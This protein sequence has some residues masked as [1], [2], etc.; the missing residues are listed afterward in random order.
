[1]ASSPLDAA[2]ETLAT[3]ALGSLGHA[4]APDHTY[5]PVATR[6]A[7][8]SL[9]TVPGAHFI[10][11]D[12]VA[13]SSNAT[14]NFNPLS[15]RLRAEH[16]SSA[17]SPLAPAPSPLDITS[18]PV[19]PVSVF[20]T[21]P[22]SWSSDDPITSP[23]LVSLAHQA[24][25]VASPTWHVDNPLALVVEGS[26]ARMV[27]GPGTPS[28]HP[29]LAGEAVI[30]TSLPKL[31]I[32]ATGGTVT[33][34]TTAG[35][36]FSIGDGVGDYELEATGKPASINAALNNFYYNPTRPAWI[37]QTAGAVA[38]GAPQVVF[39][40]T[41]PFYS[42]W[43]DGIFR[44]TLR[45]NAT[46]GDAGSLD[47]PLYAAPHH[48]L[49]LAL[50][51]ATP[52]AAGPHTT[53]T[54]VIIARGPLPA[55]VSAPAFA[56]TLDTVA[57]TA[58][59]TVSD[60]AS[61]SP[62]S[63]SVLVDVS[64]QLASGTWFHLVAM[65]DAS[66]SELVLYLDGVRAPT[67]LG[68][69]TLPATF[70]AN[71]VAAG[72]FGPGPTTLGGS[73]SGWLGDV[74]AYSVPLTPQ[75]VSLLVAFE[76]GFVRSGCT[77]LVVAPAPPP[78]PPPSPPPPFAPPS[79]PAFAGHSPAGRLIL[80]PPA[81]A[82]DVV[83][84]I[85]TASLR[86]STETTLTVDPDA[87]AA[88]RFAVPIPHGARIAA[89]HLILRPNTV[90]PQTSIT[91]ITISAES[92][93][94]APQLTSASM[95]FTRTFSP[96]SVLWDVGHFLPQHRHFA[97]PS[98]GRSPDLAAILQERVDDPLWTK[99]SHV[100]FRLVAGGAVGA[101]RT[102]Y[103]TTTST[104]NRHIYAPR[105]EIEFHCHV[106]GC[107]PTLVPPPSSA[108]APIG[109]TLT[110][111]AFLISDP[112]VLSAFIA[113]PAKSA[114]DAY[115]ETTGG[116]YPGDVV[117]TGTTL[118]FGYK[119]GLIFSRLVF[120]A[121]GL[122]HGAPVHSAAI[123]VAAATSRYGTTT[124]LVYGDAS[125]PGPAAI[126]ADFDISSR[127]RTAASV[128]FGPASMP[129]TQVMYPLTSNIGPILS[130]YTAKPTWDE[131]ADV[132]V[133]VEGTGGTDYRVTYAMDH[134]YGEPMYMLEGAFEVTGPWS[135]TVSV[136]HGN[137]GL[138]PLPA[139]L[140]VTSGSAAGDVHIEGSAPFHV[141]ESL[142]E[143]GGI[144]YT[145]PAYTVV[146]VVCINVTEP[147]LD[148]VFYLDARFTFD[149]AGPGAGLDS[150]RTQP[151]T[152]SLAGSSALATS[153][154]ALPDA[155]HYTAALGA[156]GSVLLPASTAPWLAPN[157][158]D[159][160]LAFWALLPAGAPPLPSALVSFGLG[161][162]E[163]GMELVSVAPDWLTWVV[164]D[165]QTVDPAPPLVNVT[166]A[167]PPSPS[168]TWHHFG[169]SLSR[170]FAEFALYI[171]GVAAGSYAWDDNLDP[172]GT[173]PVTASL[174]GSAALA[175]S[176][177]ALMCGSTLMRS[178]LS[179]CVDV[180]V[181]PPP[182]PPPSPPPPSPPPP[183]PP[184]PSPPSPPPPSPPPPSPPPLP[185]PS[186]PA[187]PAPPVPSAC[188]SNVRD[189]AGHCNGFAVVDDCGVCSGGQTGL[190]PNADKDH[191]GVCF[192]GNADKDDCGVCRGGNA[193]KDVCGVCWGD[194][195]SCAGCDG[196]PFSGQV[197]DV[198][199]VCG[200]D[201]T[202][203]LGCN[204][205]PMSAGGRT[206]DTC[207]V[208]GGPH[209]A[210]GSCA[211]TCAAG[212]YHDCAGVCGGSALVDLC[213]VCW[214]A[215]DYV[216][217]A[218][219][220]MDDCG[221]C[222][223]NNTAK[224]D[225]GV[226]GGTNADKDSCGVCGGNN[227]ARDACG[228]CYGFNYSVDACGLCFGESRTC[229]GCDGVPNSG[230][231]FDP[232]GA[233]GGACLAATSTSPVRTKSSTG[234]TVGVIAASATALCLFLVVAALV[235][236]MLRMRSSQ[237]IAEER[238]RRAEVKEI[239]D[240][241]R[242]T[243]TANGR[244]PTGNVT[245][246]FTRIAENTALWELYPEVM[247]LL[248]VAHSDI[249]RGILTEFP[250]GYEVKLE[251]DAFMLAF[252]DPLS[253][254]EFACRT[255][256]ELRTYQWKEHVEAKGVVW[257]RTSSLNEKTEFLNL[258]VSMGVHGGNVLS[259][260]DERTQR[261]DYYGTVV[262]RAA[263]I[264]A[265]DT[266]NGAITISEYSLN[267]ARAIDAARTEA[268]A[269]FRC[270]GEKAFKGIEDAIMIYAVIP[271]NAPGSTEMSVSPRD[272]A[273]APSDADHGDDP[274][275]AIEA[276][277]SARGPRPTSK[278]SKS[279]DVVGIVH[280]QR[281]ASR[282]SL[283]RASAARMQKV[284]SGVGSRSGRAARVLRSRAAA[285]RAR[286]VRKLSAHS[287]DNEQRNGVSDDDEIEG[288]RAATAR[289]G[290]SV[291]VSSASLTDI[292]PVRPRA[293]SR[294]GSR[295]LAA[296]PSQ[297][298]RTGSRTRPTVGS[299]V[300]SVRRNRPASKSVE[301][302]SSKG[303]PRSRP[304]SRSLGATDS[305]SRSRSRSKSR[306]RTD[307]RSAL[308]ARLTSPPSSAR[309]SSDDRLNRSGGTL[310]LPEERMVRAG[311]IDTLASPMASRFTPILDRSASTQ[312]LS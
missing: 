275:D 11:L 16:A 199:G 137:V 14:A 40:A 50:W 140:V 148:D 166:L 264:S 83:E 31:F 292:E 20:W 8:H 18:R 112:D 42:A 142:L 269:R 161:P 144:T 291:L 92:I 248:L 6:L 91:N 222:F 176:A 133:I 47:A 90:V 213:G 100:M 28:F 145:P 167:W 110:L 125:Q 96:T 54:P 75:Q 267:M 197:F 195:S 243:E 121:A 268:V 21:L 285:S 270:E 236:I 123:Y 180:V 67:P 205:L 65:Y 12:L 181:T 240:E 245:F 263:R 188:E 224:D 223:G 159:W 69:V 48:D 34:A 250:A 109:T 24:D 111:P 168:P 72:G 293:L 62:I 15:L 235:G 232:C 311:S 71:V 279:D 32:N 255:S 238:M 169:I 277:T 135:F 225:C 301:R 101:S 283:S 99:D 78:S 138:T 174:A 152:A 162:G 207:G 73:F 191:C 280:A 242:F 231:V 89:A 308:L 164:R 312:A 209:I 228:I 212:A 187:P 4:R 278:S 163:P 206:I 124:G 104:A 30:G 46:A 237:P 9:G 184:P 220:H 102:F 158:S 202:S 70:A 44:G 26:G 219:M 60:G 265:Y 165:D 95:L 299:R 274:D 229:L 171:D 307:A 58:V 215:T 35:L 7:F 84:V 185:P 146:D 160:S 43:G 143:G 179:A 81:T 288:Q 131:S 204:G 120:P 244:A 189:C 186:P 214:S 153:A 150:I 74:R 130:E 302:T 105:L 233:C 182:P 139:G 211:T 306:S 254:L 128:P 154:V 296:S 201:G 80:N 103:G 56:L 227:A 127:P 247:E 118:H 282:A 61:S 1:M 85:S 259:T 108:T 2:Y 19:A 262:N 257:P 246:I 106:A 49:S 251:A 98:V 63:A 88:V 132:H 239:I 41:A 66:F 208:C 260:V 221:V 194:G 216:A 303:S 136:S 23:S 5:V 76:A 217:N 155:R 252:A 192:G 289:P 266:S 297:R 126:A 173:Q 87:M 294:V 230:K 27:H 38:A 200:G 284:R 287:L 273:V 115:E 59:F 253:A 190:V 305:Q 64:S 94:D 258:H 304:D 276:A 57:G 151:V 116:A 295:R 309:R 141:L 39:D 68:S 226:C 77:H 10:T 36:A 281:A 271:H 25:V 241:N 234:L 53:T 300:G 3:S 107:G 51:V 122:P 52:A 37:R 177:V 175:T 196:A 55:V 147:L 256:V 134:A 183:S 286:P 114:D 29:Y 79:P 218:N 33:L 203:C 149:P 119:S 82:D 113:L 157:G 290:T 156:S 170:R 261:M 310:A 193:G 13:S 97:V 178:A 129:S 272:I 210:P 93:R 249:V 86:S 17:L 198:C 45:L 22:S 172:V 298:S 117:D